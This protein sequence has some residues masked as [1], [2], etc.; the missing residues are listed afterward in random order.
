MQPGEHSFT[1]QHPT[2]GLAH[3]SFHCPGLH[4]AGA[5]KQEVGRISF[6]DILKPGGP[7]LR[8]PPFQRAY[9]WNH[10]LAFGWWRDCQRGAH[11]TG[12]A[13][14]CPY[15]GGDPHS[16]LIV[17]D[18]QQRLTTTCL[19]LAALRD[20]TLRFLKS[21]EAEHAVRLVRSCEAALFSDPHSANAWI[22]ESREKNAGEQLGWESLLPTDNAVLPFLR[23]TP[24]LRDRACFAQ[25]LVAGRLG[26]AVDVSDCPMTVVKGYFDNVVKGLGIRQLAMGIRSALKGMSVMA[27]TLVQ[28]PTGLPQQVYQWSQERALASSIEIANPSPGVWLAIS[29]LVRNMVLAPLLDR[30]AAETEEVLQQTWLPL[31][32]RFETPQ[33]FDAFLQRFVDANPRAPITSSTAPIIQAADGAQALLGKCELSDKMRLYG[34]MVAE[35]DVVAAECGDKFILIER[36]VSK[37]ERF[38]VHGLKVSAASSSLE[39]GQEVDDAMMMP[40]PMKLT[41][42]H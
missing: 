10:N 17:I 20:A 33:S 38:A 3:L 26:M 41:R 8:I 6:G 37:L 5:C 27:I 9:C 31:E 22:K 30:S 1:V 13:L 18:G 15:P 42:V 21:S 7:L 25:L 32:M 23:L 28:P 39:P 24:T 11:S 4:G 29:D 14:F 35:Y 12:K 40:P 19:L 16:E 2:H 36:L 34:S